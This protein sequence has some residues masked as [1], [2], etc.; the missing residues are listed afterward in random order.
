MSDAE[1][2]DWD[3]VGADDY[4]GEAASAYGGA[5]TDGVTEEDA[6]G[7][8]RN[9]DEKAESVGG[10][11]DGGDVDWRAVWDSCNIDSTHTLSRTQLAGAIRV[12]DATGDAVES[13]LDHLTQEAVD[14][15][16]LHANRKE[17]ATW[18]WLP[19]EVQDVDE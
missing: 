17:R 12:A 8:E 9:A 13:D 5:D 19:E 14:A 7:L 11:P 18:F 16:V 4:H 2:I 3:G 15:E 10:I 1:N 6:V